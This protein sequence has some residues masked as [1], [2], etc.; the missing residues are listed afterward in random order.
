MAIEDLTARALCGVIEK[1]LI[2]EGVSPE[3]AKELSERACHPVV[4][5]GTRKAKG[6]VKR[7]AT[8]YQKRYGAAFRKIASKYKPKPGKWKKDG[9]K[10]AQRA[11]HRM[12][13]K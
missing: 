6:V 3:I 1:A 4:K 9:F 2:A 11:A 10:R 12:A 5:A 8:A 13:K 7:K